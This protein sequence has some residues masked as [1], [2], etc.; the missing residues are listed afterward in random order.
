V[1]IRSKQLRSVRVLVDTRQISKRG[2]RTFQVKVGV[3]H[4]KKGKHHLTARA[5]DWVGRFGLKSV[6]FHVCK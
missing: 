3:S 6:V 5:R 2:K 4:L 1:K